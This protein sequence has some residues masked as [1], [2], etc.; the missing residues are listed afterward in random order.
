MYLHTVQ[1]AAEVKAKGPYYEESNHGLFV[2]AA[3]RF[4]MQK[5]EIDQKRAKKAWP[6]T[7]AW[8]VSEAA[9]ASDV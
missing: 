5:L 1:T 9:T 7:F 2:D 6:V 3:S 4:G 8:F